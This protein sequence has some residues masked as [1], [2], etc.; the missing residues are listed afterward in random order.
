MPHAPE[1]S[2]TQRHATPSPSTPSRSQSHRKR[3]RDDSPCGARS[4]G[5]FQGGVTGE[6]EK[7]GTAACASGLLQ[8]RAAHRRSRSCHPSGLT[9]RRCL[10][11]H[12]RQPRPAFGAERARSITRRSC[13]VSSAQHAS[14]SSRALRSGGRTMTGGPARPSLDRPPLPALRAEAVPSC[15]ASCYGT[16]HTQTLRRRARRVQAGSCGD[17]ATVGA[18]SLGRDALRHARLCSGRPVSSARLCAA[19]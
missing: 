7:A 4:K 6:S 19:P 15:G 8:T 14:S 10:C 5:R 11:R 18:C 1:C 9:H 17:S 2:R 12:P 16:I 13:G 3:C